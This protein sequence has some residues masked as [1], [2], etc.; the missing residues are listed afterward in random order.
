M[1]LIILVPV[2]FEQINFN[3]FPDANENRIKSN[4]NSN[5]VHCRVS[6]P[7]ISVHGRRVADEWG[8]TSEKDCFNLL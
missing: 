6:I 7:G 5:T 3:L 4:K 2:K 8:K 1:G